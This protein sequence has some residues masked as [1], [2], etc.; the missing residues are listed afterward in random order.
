M[1]ITMLIGLILLPFAWAFSGAVNKAHQDE[2]GID[3]PIR[4][5]MRNIRRNS[6]KKGISE[7]QAYSEWLSRMQ[8]RP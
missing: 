6:R 4:N 8:K 2:T 7:E 5:D 1:T 3:A